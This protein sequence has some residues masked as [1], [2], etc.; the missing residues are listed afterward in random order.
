MIGISPF[1]VGSGSRELSFG[2]GA[3]AEKGQKN[4]ESEVEARFLDPCK[5]SA[6]ACVRVAIAQLERL[7]LPLPP[8]PTVV[9]VAF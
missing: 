7:F 5:G 4:A 3:W 9:V 1:R 8:Y 6:L 2:D